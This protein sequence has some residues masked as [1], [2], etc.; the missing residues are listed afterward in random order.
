VQDSVSLAEYFWEMACDQVPAEYHPLIE[1]IFVVKIPRD[2][3]Y[4]EVRN[5]EAVVVAFDYDGYQLEIYDFAEDAMYAFQVRRGS[6]T[7]N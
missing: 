1:G 4:P 2:C 6:R 7:L 3:P 5:K